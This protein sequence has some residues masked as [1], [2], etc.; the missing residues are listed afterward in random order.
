MRDPPPCVVIAAA[1]GFGSGRCSFPTDVCGPDGDAT[2][3]AVTRHRL[4]ALVAVV[5]AIAIFVALGGWTFMSDGDRVEEFF[6]ERGAL[7]P[8]VFVLAMWALQ[9][10]GIPGAV[11]MIPAAVVWPLPTAMGLSWVGNMGASTIAFSMAR[12][13]ARDWAQNHMPTRLKGWDERLAD[14]GVVQVT[15]LRVVTG[16]LTPA[17][18]L[19]GI[20]NVRL[21][22]FFVGTALGIIPGIVLVTTV[23]GGIFELLS[24]RR[25][26]LPVILVVVAIVVI[27]RMRGRGSAAPTP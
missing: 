15:L 24:D 19:L 5:A 9:P 6:T 2:L 3:I 25:V 16:Q 7:G 13:L 20:S 4:L 26:R 27:R 23:G 8:I 11:F 22:T 18:W 14:G 10:A 21:R 12:W 17:D 1:S